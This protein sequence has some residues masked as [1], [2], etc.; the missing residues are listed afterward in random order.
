MT[1][2]L[3]TSLSER[4]A[5]VRENPPATYTAAEQA[6]NYLLYGKDDSGLSAV[7]RGYVTIKPKHD[8]SKKAPLSL[9]ELIES[10]T[11]IET[12]TTFSRTKYKTPKPHFSR[13]ENANLPN[14]KDL[15]HSIDE[16]EK[17]LEN[18]NPQSRKY[19]DFKHLLVEL[20]KDQY[21][22]RD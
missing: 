9:D 2:N 21:L 8:Y 4:I 17:V 1:Y 14:I 20:R 5:L 13:E 11:F 7:D 3:N 6:A 16:V 10:P 19:Y 18:T 22:L 12:P 15:W